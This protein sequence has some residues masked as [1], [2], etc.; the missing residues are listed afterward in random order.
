LAEIAIILRPR[1]FESGNICGKYHRVNRVSVVVE[2]E[3]CGSLAALSRRVR[4]LN[5]YSA[6]I[7]D[8]CVQLC[9]DV[10]AAKPVRSVA[11]QA[12]RGSG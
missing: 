6:T 8:R 1:I 11:E 12:Q 10:E 5:V 3:K 9:S 7:S 4:A 2:R